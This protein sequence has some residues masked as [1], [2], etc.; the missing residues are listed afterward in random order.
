M[1]SK[2]QCRI[3]LGTNLPILSPC[4]CRG[5][6]KFV[7]ERCLLQWISQKG[8]ERCEVCGSQVVI[9]EEKRDTSEI[10]IQ[11][12]QCILT[13]WRSI[14]SVKRL[15]YFVFFG[16]YVWV[17]IGRFKSL[18]T[19]D[20]PSLVAMM[21]QPDSKSYPMTALRKFF[22]SMLLSLV[23]LSELLS[24]LPFVTL[25]FAQNAESECHSGSVLSFLKQMRYIK[26]IR[27][28]E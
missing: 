8:I 2:S 1:T 28:L 15:L 12:A 11:V 7:H 6:I 4:A 26:R 9:Y 22:T 23:L 20:L 10:A 16:L 25:L 5:S 14:F 19:Q 18:L 24:T 21:K 27:N 3:C 17:I 13:E